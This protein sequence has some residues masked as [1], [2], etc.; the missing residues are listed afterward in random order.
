MQPAP[1]QPPA[2][3]PQPTGRWFPRPVETAVAAGGALL[4]AALAAVSD[5]AGRVLFGLAAIGLLALTAVD[6]LLRPR[7]A[8]D[9]T[10]VR[11]RTLGVRRRLPWSALERVDVDERNRYGLTARTLELDA[12]GMLVVLG[13][14]SLGADPREVADALARI[15]YTSPQASGVDQ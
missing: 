6:L 1:A 9:P 14:R 7:L 2:G 8:A 11:I 12:G 3:R 13:R 4:A 5:P 15:R 10:G